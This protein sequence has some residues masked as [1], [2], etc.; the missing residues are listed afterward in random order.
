MSLFCSVDLVRKTRTGERVKGSWVKGPEVET[1]FRGTVQPPSG[2][3]MKVL[4]EGT[5]KSDV[6]EVIAPRGMEFTVADPETGEKSDL[7]V[8][9]GR[10]YEIVGAVLMDNGLLPH[11]E[12]IAQ[13]SKEGAA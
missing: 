5:R 1:L 6:I 13:R 7:I 9:Q 11:W 8:W 12:L 4:P 10:E 2:E 3:T